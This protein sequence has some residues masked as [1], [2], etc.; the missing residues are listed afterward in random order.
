[1]DVDPWQATLRCWKCCSRLRRTSTL[2]IAR[3]RRRS[4][5]QLMRGIR[6]LVSIVLV[7]TV[8][9]L[10]DRLPYLYC[11]LLYTALYALYAFS[12]RLGCRSCLLALNLTYV[13]VSV[14]SVC[15]CVCRSSCRAAVLLSNMPLTQTPLLQAR[16]M[17]ASAARCQGTGQLAEQGS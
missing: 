17:C 14:V 2:A 11:C 10:A 12:L 16:R 1:M 9:P 7:S 5:L 8:L 3:W 13:C 4:S 6:V 15:L